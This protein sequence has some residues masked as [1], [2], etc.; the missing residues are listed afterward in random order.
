MTELILM[1]SSCQRPIYKQ[2]NYNVLAYPNGKV[3]QFRYGSKY[4]NED[5]WASPENIVGKQTLIIIVNE[6]KE[7]IPVR[8]GKIVKA[9]ISDD[10]LFVQFELLNEWVDYTDI[11]NEYHSFLSKDDAPNDTGK[12]YL[13]G[14]LF[15]RHL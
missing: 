14:K 8:K 9:H 4:V 12:L 5:I 2:D 6:D 15:S 10:T 3:M 1:Y 7:F 11:T 13:E